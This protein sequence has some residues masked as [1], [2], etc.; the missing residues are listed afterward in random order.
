MGEKLEARIFF[1]WG[2]QL[3][4]TQA[5]A[6]RAMTECL[7]NVNPPLVHCSGG[8]VEEECNKALSRGQPLL[9]EG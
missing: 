2:R 7:N 3:S 1:K 8:D 9:R 5:R 6:G 4:R